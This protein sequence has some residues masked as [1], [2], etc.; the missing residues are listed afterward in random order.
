MGQGDN[1]SIRHRFF[2]ARGITQEQQCT[3][4]YVSICL[5][6]VVSTV[7]VMK[8]YAGSARKSVTG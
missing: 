3:Y 6:K 7:R 5:L 2:L 8:M 4:Y 1:Q